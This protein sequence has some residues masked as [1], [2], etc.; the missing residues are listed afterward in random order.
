VHQ[1]DIQ[2]TES[3]PCKIVPTKSKKK[4]TTSSLTVS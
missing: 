3:R 1:E 2:L 4:R